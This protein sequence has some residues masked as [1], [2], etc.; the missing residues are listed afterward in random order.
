M[1][2]PM[3]NL[4]TRTDISTSGRFPVVAIPQYCGSP[5]GASNV[6]VSGA[7]VVSPRLGPRSKQL[8]Y[9]NRSVS[10]KTIA[11]PAVAKLK[12]R[13]SEPALCTW[14]FYRHWNLDG[15]RELAPRVR[16]LQPDYPSE[17]HVIGPDKTDELLESMGVFLQVRTSG[18]AITPDNSSNDSLNRSSDQV[19]PESQGR[20]QANSTTATS[21]GKL[22]TDSS[23]SH[24]PS[25]TRRTPFYQHQ[26]G[27]DLQQSTSQ[28]ALDEKSVDNKSS[29]LI[30]GG[31]K[32]L[33]ELKKGAG[34]VSGGL[35]KGAHL[36]PP[37]KKG[38]FGG[39]VMPMFESK[40]K[41]GESSGSTSN[42]TSPKEET[43]AN[44]SPSHSPRTSSYLAQPH[45]PR[46][47]ESKD[48]SR[49][50]GQDGSSDSSP[51]H[52]TPTKIAKEPKEP[53]SPREV[54]N[55]RTL[56]SPREKSPFRLS[57]DLASKKEK[58]DGPRSPRESHRHSA[59]ERDHVDEDG[60][61]ATSSGKKR[62]GGLAKNLKVTNLVG[63]KSSND[64]SASPE[65]PLAAGNQAS[66]D[67][68][69]S[70]SFASGGSTTIGY[71]VP[72]QPS[73]IVK[74]DA[75]V[76]GSISD[77]IA[78]ASENKP[79]LAQFLS[80]SRFILK[81]GELITA[82]FNNYF[83]PENFNVARA[84]IKTTA[85]ASNLSQSNG[86][87]GKLR[88]SLT[89]GEQKKLRE[90]AVNPRE[91]LESVMAK[92]ST[93]LQNLFELLMTAIETGIEEE[94]NGLDALLMALMYSDEIKLLKKTSLVVAGDLST[95]VKIIVRKKLGLTRTLSNMDF[96][97]YTFGLNLN[98]S[99]Y[100]TEE[101][102]IQHMTNLCHKSFFK[103]RDSDITDI[104][105]YILETNLIKTT[106]SIMKLNLP[107]EKLVAARFHS[108]CFCVPDRPCASAFLDFHGATFAKQLTLYA[109][110]LF[111]RI[112]LHEFLYWIGGKSCQSPSTA[113]NSSTTTAS[114]TTS[115]NSGDKSLDPRKVKSPN[116]F[117]ATA[118]SNQVSA[119]T[120]T[121]IL[122]T[123]NLKQRVACIRRLIAL[124]S[125]CWAL[126][127]ID[128]TL[129]ICYGLDHPAV[130]R[131]K[132]T[133]KLL[134]DSYPDAVSDLKMLRDCVDHTS[135][136]NKNF[137]FM[138]K[139][140]EQLAREKK[141]C[142]P[143]LGVHLRD[144]IYT[145]D[146]SPSFVEGGH[147]SWTKMAK[148]AKIFQSFLTTQ[149]L[150]VYNFTPENAIQDYLC[151]NLYGADEK[152]KYELSKQ[153]ECNT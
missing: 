73:I 7:N 61:G 114:S 59:R 150:C 119:W 107:K 34:S 117:A 56:K 95:L 51:S 24:L 53:K 92:K 18:D 77:L 68:G 21:T 74:D 44:K 133:W 64:V 58:T 20:D 13:H 23:S 9:S 148:L 91:Q 38:F 142:V 28:S 134:K 30:G 43:K 16:F 47:R 19:S 103:I 49:D 85:S 132:S 128:A 3:L 108:Q 35:E 72:L 69:H 31:G 135:Q 104:N 99:E 109:S 139:I 124:A 141:P 63:T 5:R 116:L 66:V 147:V 88:R 2:I 126:G 79:F 36:L 1:E 137:A 84:D 86:K 143:Y 81:P 25:L 70:V 75:I 32:I 33:R 83:S 115:T 67:A 54:E 145:N 113:S 60:N 57:I 11:L 105:N 111:R 101:F 146:A 106:K 76:S 153:L 96:F 140:S 78:F 41:S 37:A 125:A 27:K 151:N 17:I 89:Q 29:G 98:D 10:M 14:D 144:L 97:L 123:P 46:G 55:L 62:I 87:Q 65:D 39:T 131:L 4:V 26:N 6:N 45:S 22:F 120:T 52:A 40:H 48:E 122:N 71:C 110:L 102:F 127:N 42:G 50:T 149:S 82:I 12:R 94:G 15:A 118:F 93:N 8:K 136:Q 100:F 129:Q 90:P 130:S 138:R 121:E 152:S 112:A 80:V